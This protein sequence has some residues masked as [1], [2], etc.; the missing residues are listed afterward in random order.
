[1]TL[2]TPMD[3][4]IPATDMAAIDKEDIRYAEAALEDRSAPR[5]K[6]RIP[7]ILRPSGTAGYHVTISD[8]SLSGFSAEAL[9]CQP[10][11]SRL[12]I[13]IP[14]LTPLQAEIVRNDGTI[15]GC[16]FSNFLNQAVLDNLVARYRVEE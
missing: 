10:P 9:T 6:L 15:V 1:M 5:V 11:G 13:T 12:W 3:V 2:D 4:K 8:L 7:A 14:G 16:A